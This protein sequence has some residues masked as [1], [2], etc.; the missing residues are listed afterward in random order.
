MATYPA[1]PPVFTRYS[2]GTVASGFIVA[3]AIISFL[4]FGREIILPLVIAALLAFVLAPV[5]RRLRGVGMWNAP[6]VV[7]TVALA[8]L[9]I[10]G[11]GYTIVM[12]VTQLAGDLPL[13]QT[14][15]RTKIR[16]LSGSPAASSTIDRAAGTLRELQE[17]ITK[18]APP[19]TGAEV[20]TAKPVPVEVRQP[21]A[22][23]LEALANLIRPPAIPACN[24]GACDPVLV[25]HP[26]GA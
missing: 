25:F 20:T 22:T 12:Q 19:S 14:N 26:A 3:A 15:L 16:A 21:Q 5:I 1:A 24:H 6:A 17:E 11:L 23:G 10:G 9:G 7:L 8:I 4:H 13:Y 18:P 2:L